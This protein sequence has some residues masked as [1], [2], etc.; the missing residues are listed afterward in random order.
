MESHI[1]NISHKKNTVSCVDPKTYSERFIKYINVLTD[2][3]QF[4]SKEI[5]EEDKI[6]EKDE[7]YLDD[8]DENESLVK[9]M[10]KRRATLSLGRDSQKSNQNQLLIQN[11]SSE[12]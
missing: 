6:E 4:L 11:E 1:K 2:V 8:E 12:N 3:K 9:R 10:Q 5:K 7:E